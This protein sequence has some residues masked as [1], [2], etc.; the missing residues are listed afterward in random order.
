MKNAFTMVELVFVIVVLG[1]LS[2]IALP[3]MNASRDDAEIVRLMTNIK[4]LTSDITNYYNANGCLS[5]NP[6]F[7]SNVATFS[8]AAGGAHAGN[9]SCL[10][11][12]GS[13]SMH[14]R[15]KNKPCY[16]LTYGVSEYMGA[17][18]R[19]DGMSAGASNACELAHNQATMKSMRDVSFTYTD[20]T[21]ANKTAK[22]TRI[23]GLNPNKF[24]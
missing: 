7:M 18:V 12:G 8:S 16:A 17:W 10:A 21:G 6:N 19:I 3:R 13:V 23:G 11:N 22:G 4:T 2:S 5:N 1:I 14:I 20:E 24:R 9:G 15:V